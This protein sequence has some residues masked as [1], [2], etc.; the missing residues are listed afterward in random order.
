MGRSSVRSGMRLVAVLSLVA[1]ALAGCGPTASSGTVAPAAQPAAGPSASA[2]AAGAPSA[3]ASAGDRAAAP[4]GW[5][6]MVA[7]AK[8]EG[9]LVISAPANTIWRE[10]LTAFQKDYPE[11]QVEYTG[12]NSRDFWPRVAQERAGG[13]Y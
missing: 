7:A 2:P 13:Q 10:Q 12:G 11:I 9:R 4:A 3:A 5:D 8:Q 6:E 1:L